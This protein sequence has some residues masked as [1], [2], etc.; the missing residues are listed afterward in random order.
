MN[1][2]NKTFPYPVLRPGHD[3]V[4]GNIS[5]E[6]QVEHNTVSYFL[7]Y[8][9]LIG[10]TTIKQLLDENK[11]TLNLLL[12][13]QSNFYRRVFSVKKPE[14]V[15]EINAD[16]ISGKV[17]VSFF[18]TAS[19]SI[20]EYKIIGQHSDYKNNSFSIIKGD[21]LAAGDIQAFYADK[22]YDSLKQISSIISIVKLNEKDFGPAELDFSED[23]IKV[24][25]PIKLYEKYQ[26]M[27]D[28][29]QFSSS[30]AILVFM[31][32]LMRIIDTWISDNNYEMEMECHLWFRTIRAKLLSLNIDIKHS[33]DDIFVIAQKLFDLPFDRC[34][35][36]LLEFTKD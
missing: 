6:L 31:P 34:I 5:W 32:I 12:E 8:N 3:D 35:N 7:R 10:N 16:F 26:L 25:M 29:H 21:I 20:Q 19:I 1:I 15:L 14:D 33:S 4:S 22:E 24:C 18:I 28:T 30:I 23:K 36:E 9:I 13:C 2:L 17:S 27:Q 11:A